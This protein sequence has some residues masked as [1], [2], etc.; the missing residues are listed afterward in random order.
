MERPRAKSA[1]YDA[2]RDRVVIRLTTGIEIGF[3]P[4]QAEGLEHAKAEDLAEIEITPTGQGVHFP[5]LDADLYTPHCWKA[6][7]VRRAG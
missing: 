6:S 2:G 1:H 7:W 5:K 4:R 3:A